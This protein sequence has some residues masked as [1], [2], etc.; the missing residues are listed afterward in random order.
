MSNKLY[1]YSLSSYYSRD[2][3]KLQ[4]KNNNLTFRVKPGEL[5]K[6]LDV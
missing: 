6:N 1:F 3:I 5:R 2:I 4:Y